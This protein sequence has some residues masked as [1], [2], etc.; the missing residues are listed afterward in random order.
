[1]MTIE[2]PNNS[3][4]ALSTEPCR[5]WVFDKC[6][7]LFLTENSVI[8][9]QDLGVINCLRKHKIEANITNKSGFKKNKCWWEGVQQGG[10]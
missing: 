5:Q 1:M 7:P 4:E 2:K 3:C 9:R 10:E 8:N 6:I